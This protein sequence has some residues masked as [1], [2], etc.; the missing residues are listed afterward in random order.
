MSDQSDEPTPAGS[1]APRGDRGAGW[2]SWAKLLFWSAIGGFVAIAAITLFGGVVIPP[3]IVFALLWLIGAFLVARRP[4][5]AAILLL[6]TFVL[7]VALSAPFILPTLTVP[8]SAGDFILNIASVVP[9]ILGIVAAIAVLRR[10]DVAPSRTPRTL[11]VA[12]LAVIVLAAAVGVIAMVT[13]EGA[14]AEEGDIT[15]VTEGIEFDQESLQAAGGTVAV[16]VD[17]KD[18]T[19]HTFTI[20]ELDVNLTI[21]AR[22][23]ARVEFDAEPG[24]YTFYCVPHE[25]DMEGTLQVE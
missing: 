14:A 22:S 13:Y 8:A 12:G 25:A 21:P 16:H 7:F 3:L 6:I 20:D 5:A 15:L 11:G 18:Q 17:N 23:T 19:L 1:T 2:F 10:R 4:K 24:S 9:A